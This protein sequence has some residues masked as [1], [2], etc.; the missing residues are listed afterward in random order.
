MMKRIILIQANQWKKGNAI[1][2]IVNKNLFYKHSTILTA[3]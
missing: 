3:P 2:A 1:I